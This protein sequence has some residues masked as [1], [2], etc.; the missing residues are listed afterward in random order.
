MNNPVCPRCGHRFPWVSAL[1]DI[2]GPGRPGTAL[3]G[4]VCPACEADLKVPNSRVLLIAF[5][6]IF[7]GSQSSTLFQLADI[8]RWPFLLIQIFLVLGFYAIGI[9]IFLSLEEVPE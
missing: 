3:W 1:R 2:L 7:F 5:G 8:G 6:G 4:T 9:F